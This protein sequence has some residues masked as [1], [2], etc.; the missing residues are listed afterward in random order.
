MLK[1]AR[2]G[3]RG[4][5]IAVVEPH[6]YT[7]VR[8]L[9]DEFAM[10]FSDADSVILTPLYSAGEAPI[11]GIDSARLA[12]LLRLAEYLERSKSQVIQSLQVELGDSIRVVTRAVG[13]ATVEIWDANRSAGLFKKAFG[14]EIEI[15]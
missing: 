9:F 14:K 4:N 6:R 1:A 5:V 8:D 15:V 10:C 3:A 13:D 7:R 12:A 11:D 2:A